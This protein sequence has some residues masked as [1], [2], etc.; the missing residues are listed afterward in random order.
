[1][2]SLALTH[3]QM[4]FVETYI[5]NGGNGTAAARAAGY[6]GTAAT[7]GAVAHENL[8]N[9][10]IQSEISRRQQEIRHQLE[11]ST[12]AKREQLW[13]IAQE[14]ASLH[15]VNRRVEESTTEDGV[16]VRTVTVVLTPFDPKVAIRAIH[17]LNL[18]DGDCPG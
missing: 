7:L 6:R 11:I 16:V 5:Q 13:A 12:Q 8:K 9:P 15:E 2:T 3:K 4:I 10:Y 1:M 18:M 17:E 14:A